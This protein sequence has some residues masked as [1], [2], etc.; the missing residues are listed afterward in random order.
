[1]RKRVERRRRIEENS[2]KVDFL[3]HHGLF[4]YFITDTTI[5][6][7]YL[8]GLFVLLLLF[9]LSSLVVF[10]SFTTTLL[11]CKWI[12]SYIACYFPCLLDRINSVL[13]LKLL[14]ILLFQLYH[15]HYQKHQGRAMDTYTIHRRN[16]F[17]LC[18]L[19]LC[20]FS[21]VSE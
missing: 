5:I 21:F 17:C 19:F 20:I 4:S 3:L 14:S 9:P 2:K 16:T 8:S 15:R 1:M 18:V 11:A 12:M 13:M 10:L 7:L 6:P